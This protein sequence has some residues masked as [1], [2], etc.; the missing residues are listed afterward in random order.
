MKERL[1]PGLALLPPL[2]FLLA[3]LLHRAGGSEVQVGS[4]LQQALS[5]EA[6]RT[7]QHAPLPAATY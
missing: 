2:R 3:L 6:P 5:N 7:E 1:K 4:A